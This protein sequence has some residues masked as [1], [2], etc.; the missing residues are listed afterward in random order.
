MF[1]S[2]LSNDH[3]PKIGQPMRIQI[4]RITVKYRLT[5]GLI[6][7]ILP[8]GKADACDLFPTSVE[9]GLGA[10]PF[11]VTAADLDDDGDLD[12]ATANLQNDDVS[13]LL[14]NGGGAFAEDVRYG[15]GDGPQ[16]LFATDLDSDG[17]VDLTTA[18]SNSDDVSALLNNG[19]GTF[20]ADVL[21]GAGDYPISVTAADL[22][23]DGNIDL[24]VA[25]YDS[26]NISVLLNCAPCD[27]DANGDGVVDPLDAGFVQARF[28]CS[29]PSDGEN[30]LFADANDDGTVDPLDVG[31]VLARFGDCP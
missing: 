9:Y 23:G 21:Y 27:G 15:A 20:A 10:A 31:Y 25:N 29:Y 12:L 6:L 26:N 3:L 4:E 16:S 30:C 22:D 18:N 17:D 11:S 24:A 2:T 14:N 7:L 8:A 13:V 28:G 1:K 19:D 5:L